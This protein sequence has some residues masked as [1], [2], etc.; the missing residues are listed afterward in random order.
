LVFTDLEAAVAEKGQTIQEGRGFLA[1]PEALDA[2]IECGFNLLALAGNHAFDLRIPGI[3][4]TIR[5]LDARKIVH[6]GTGNDVTEASAAAY[7]RTSKGTIALIASASGLIA[8]RQRD[9]LSSRGQRASRVRRQ[10]TE[11]GHRRSAGRRRQH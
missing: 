7:L 6:A 11:R 2:L 4:N 5:N 10:H 1:P 9:G 3:Q 8:G